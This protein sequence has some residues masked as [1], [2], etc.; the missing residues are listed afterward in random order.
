[1]SSPADHL[2]EVVAAARLALDEATADHAE[3]CREAA[4][5]LGRIGQCQA[6]Q[7]EI[8]RRRLAGEHSQD[9]A[10]EYAALSGDLAVLRE[11]HGEAQARAEAS[12]PERQRAALAR[13]EA[14]LLEYQRRAAFE[15]VKEHARAAEQVYMQCL[16][17]VWEAAQQQ[18]RR[19]RTFGEVFRIDQVIMNLC[20][21][22]S[23]QGLE[24]QR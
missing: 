6:R 11:L 24:I 3:A 21:F 16:R 4:A 1:M 17:A 14:D 15:Q 2:I 12:R 20:R 18:D 7:G 19:P 10:N 13:V 5:L 8:T 22:N 9:E 23:F